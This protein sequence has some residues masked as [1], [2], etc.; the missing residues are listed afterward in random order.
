MEP[1]RKGAPMKHKTAFSLLAAGLAALALFFLL[2]G[3][4]T[5]MNWWVW[6]GSMPIKRALG[7]VTD[8]LPFSEIG[9]A[10]V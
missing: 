3:N 6:R 5:A 7:A 4:A 9:R 8:C 2:R 10:H 1:N